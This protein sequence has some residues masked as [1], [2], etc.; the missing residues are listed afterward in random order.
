LSDNFITA[1]SVKTYNNF[2]FELNI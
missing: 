1:L 2:S